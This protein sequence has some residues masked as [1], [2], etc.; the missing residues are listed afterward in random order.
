M[1]NSKV[2]SKTRQ[3]VSRIVGGTVLTMDA[4]RTI[5]PDGEVEITDGRISYVGKRRIQK[6][7][8]RSTV[9]DVS[10]DIVIP[11]L[12]NTHTH[13]GMSAFRTIADD[14]KDRLRRY[15]FPLEKRF[16]TEELVYWASLHT[17]HE[18]ILGGTSTFADMYYFEER[19]AEATD[20][21]G[22][23]GILGET[24]VDFPAPDAPRPYGG[25]DR[26][27]DFS[28]QWGAHELITPA[29]APH[30]P[31]TVDDEHL[32][33]IGEISQR[34]GIPVLSHLAEMVFEVDGLRERLQKSPVEHYR[35]LGLLSNRLVAA[36]C[37]FVDQ[38]DIELLTNSKTAVSYNP[39]AN[40]K[41]GKGVAPIAALRAHGVPVGLGTD[42]PMS[43]NTMDLW[44][45]MSTAG[46]LQKVHSQDPT[47]LPAEEVFAMA[48]IEG[49]RALGLEDS[50]GSLEVGKCADV[51]VVS[52]RHPAMQPIYDHYSAL[53][54]C[55]S[56]A[57]VQ[58]LIINGV[59]VMQDRE[60]LSLDTEQIQEQMNVHAT[61][62]REMLV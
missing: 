62:I 28:A 59:L 53:V 2:F 33:A 16:V 44:S 21:A 39:I 60:V 32:R 30:A 23:R 47:T 13:I 31:Y 50:I 42:G 17:L 45:V 56:A 1:S 49:A 4:A 58:H 18:M 7:G 12:V 38:T 14:M 40:M 15:L 8:D 20:Q 22:I 27:R 9:L 41:S 46:K 55:A 35:D 37:I 3:L 5:Y 54:Y 52:T 29:L 61:A 57:Q 19:V 26:F 25:M 11:G 48:T 34:D 6:P 10:G 36:H 43:G 24:V 51:A